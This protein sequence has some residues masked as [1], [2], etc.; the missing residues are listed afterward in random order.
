MTSL[1]LA[2]ARVGTRMLDGGTSTCAGMFAR[3]HIYLVAFR[4]QVSFKCFF[5]VVQ[6]YSIVRNNQKHSANTSRKYG[7]GARQCSCGGEP[8]ASSESVGS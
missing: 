4:A 1:Y 7:S 2:C 5:W 3:A 6:L 8:F